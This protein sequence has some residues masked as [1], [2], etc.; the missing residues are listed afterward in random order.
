MSAGWIGFLLGVIVGANLAVVALG[1]T[2]AAQCGEC[3]AW[4]RKKLNGLSGSC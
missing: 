3:G 2:K 1:L 4:I